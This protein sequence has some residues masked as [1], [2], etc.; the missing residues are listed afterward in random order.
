MAGA[1]VKK[2]VSEVLTPSNHGTSPDGLASKIYPSPGRLCIANTNENSPESKIEKV[3][4]AQE[5]PEL[6]EPFI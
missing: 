1:I 6:S 4:R 5:R 3:A 2:H